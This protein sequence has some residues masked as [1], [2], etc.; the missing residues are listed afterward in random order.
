MI[1]QLLQLPQL[2]L[3]KNIIL[4]ENE[5]VLLRLK[6]V[7]QATNDDREVPCTSEAANTGSRH[8]L[9][10]DND[11]DLH[12][13]PSALD[14]ADVPLASVE[15]EIQ[16]DSSANPRHPS[17]LTSQPLTWSSAA[18][19]ETEVEPLARCGELVQC[20]S[21]ESST[22]ST[23]S[24]SIHT[25]TFDAQPQSP[26]TNS[27]LVRSTRS[28][29]QANQG[30]KRK[31]SQAE[32]TSRFNETFDSIVKLFGAEC[33]LDDLE[34]LVVHAKESKE[35]V[36][37]TLL[38][39]MFF[40]IPS[41]D[42]NADPMTFVRAVPDLVVEIEDAEFAECLVQIKNRMA[43]AHFYYAYRSAHLN[44]SMFIEWTE[45]M[46]KHTDMQLT[47]RERRRPDSI[48]KQRFIDLCTMRSRKTRQQISSDISNWQSWGK[49]W[50]ELI[51]R[52][53]YA[54]L[55]LVPRMMT[56]D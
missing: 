24:S 6:S 25:P 8:S 32:E 48:V 19:L 20:S 15:R 7:E 29:S 13:L 22:A 56:N 27:V 47:P 28:S 18:P 45:Y 9:H 39:R 34:R 21:S 12:R 36:P 33:G 14:V 2:S 55:L 16:N 49:Q 54:G 3:E 35:L 51:N 26:P 50:A 43:L 31:R 38:T 23:P 40:S 10:D 5:K 1:D 11:T 44:R 37:A 42:P 41:A 46:G 30:K 17:L 52:F 53:G 4:R